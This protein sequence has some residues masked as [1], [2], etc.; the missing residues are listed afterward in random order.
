M[1]LEAGSSQSRCWR[2]LFLV[3]PDSWLA[4]NYLLAVSSHGPA[5]K[6]EGE[7]QRGLKR[8]AGRER[9]ERELWSLPL[10][11]GALALS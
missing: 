2:S 11:I 10:T 7:R 6:G 8:E 5:R 1:V 3:R 9:E 4:G